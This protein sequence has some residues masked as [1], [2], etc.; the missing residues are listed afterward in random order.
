MNNIS[1]LQSALTFPLLEALLGR[2][3]RRFALGGAIPSGP[4][5]FASRQAPLPLTEAERL[6]LLCAMGGSSGWHFL[7]PHHSSPAMPLPNYPAAAGGRTFP[8]AAG[9]HTTELFCTDDSG[10]YFFPTRDAPAL[11]EPTVTGQVDIERWLEAHRSRLRK[12]AEGRLHLPTAYIDAHNHWCANAPGSLLLIPVADLAQHLLAVL[13][14][15]VQNGGCIY[16]NIH[17]ERIPGL[18]RFGHLVNVDN[19]APLSE[20]EL[21]CL[22]MCMAELSTSCYAG[23]L[24]LQAMGLGG[25]M[26]TG[27]DGNAILGGSGDPAVPG[28]G[29]HFDR[30][31]RWVVPNPTGL[32]GVFAGFCPPHYATMRAA[33][34]AFVERKFGPGGPFHPQTRGPWRES[35]AVRA[36]VSPHSDE[37]KACV[38]HIAQYIYDRFGK[39]PATVPSLYARIFL[40]A[41]HLDCEFYDHH[42]QPGAYLHTHAEHWAQWHG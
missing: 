9:W 6:L 39:F 21:N 13:C 42:F 18:E 22:T 30:D 41:Q 31:A 36:A 28:L 37:F 23:M 16:N 34:D 11:V 8:S 27:I 38:A 1:G 15:V 17:G 5:T 14:Y 7:L 10:V 24:M 32:P 20:I 3:S 2:R 35:A 33:V 19:P 25:W 12:L 40:Q 26:L 29:F 4:F